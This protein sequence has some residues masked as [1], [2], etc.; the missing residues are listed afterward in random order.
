MRFGA[1]LVVLFILIGLIP[2]MLVSYFAFQRSRD[3]LDEA[4]R[5]HLRSV[6]ILK[7]DELHK[8]MEGN[9]TLLE[10]V[11]TRPL[12]QQ[13][14]ADL[15]D[16]TWGSKEWNRAQDDLVSTHLRPNLTASGIKGLI[17]LHPAFAQILAATEDG[18]V[19]KFRE[20]VVPELAVSKF[21]PGAGIVGIVCN[22]GAG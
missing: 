1:K 18:L 16:E 15:T 20:V 3:S 10:S 21:G 6:S 4:T 17:I 22:L 7:D 9:T 8:W 19:G 12:V 2:V 13:L 11:A 14:T 5:N